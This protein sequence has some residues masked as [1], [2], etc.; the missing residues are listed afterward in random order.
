MVTLEQPS[1]D[2]QDLWVLAHSISIARMEVT[3][4]P[5]R[6]S[7]L[8][9]SLAARL[10]TKTRYRMG[11]IGPSVCRG[12]ISE[13]EPLQRVFTRNYTRRC[14]GISLRWR[15]LSLSP[16]CSPSN[17]V[18]Q[19]FAHRFGFSCSHPAHGGNLEGI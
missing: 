13:C 12:S 19:L 8:P 5:P 2:F 15:W 1:H 9:T 17:F 4:V 6:L 18:S 16:L 14:N 11:G 3:F 7:P 10:Q